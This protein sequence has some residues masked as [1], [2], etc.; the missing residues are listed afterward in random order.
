MKSIVQHLREKKSRPV[1]PNVFSAANLLVAGIA[2][3]AAGLFYLGVIW[4]CTNE[5]RVVHEQAVTFPA[6]DPI[7]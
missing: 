5:R 2:V 7:A 6:P 3:A 4:K 1:V